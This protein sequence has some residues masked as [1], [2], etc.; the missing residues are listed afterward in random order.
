MK[1]S[2]KGARRK[3]FVGFGDTGSCEPEKMGSAQFH[4]RKVRKTRTSRTVSRT[5]TT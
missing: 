5:A 4:G 2:L 3:K 1:E